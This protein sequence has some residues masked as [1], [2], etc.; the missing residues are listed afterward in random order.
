MLRYIQE[1]E[2]RRIGSVTSKKVDA[3]LI[4]ATHRNLRMLADNGQFREDLFYRIDVLRLEIPALR[5]RG[6]DIVNMAEWL[7]DRQAHKLGVM[8]KPLSQHSLRLLQRHRWPGNVRELQNV[9]ERALVMST[10]DELELAISNDVE[11]NPGMTRMDSMFRRARQRYQPP[12]SYPWK[13]TFSA[14]C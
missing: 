3:R 14:L 2:I 8:S 11:T 12:T 6:A 5:E 9:I 4:C 1:G 10:S 13:I 7:I